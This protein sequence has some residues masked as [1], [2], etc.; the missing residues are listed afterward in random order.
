VIRPTR[1]VAEIFVEALPKTPQGRRGRLGRPAPN[2]H[3][4]HETQV[5]PFVDH[6]C[7]PTPPGPAPLNKYPRQPQSAR[8]S[9]GRIPPLAGRSR[10]GGPEVSLAGRP[11]P[12]LAQDGMDQI[13]TVATTPANSG[14]DS[15]HEPAGT[16]HHRHA[17]PNA[18]NHPIWTPNTRQ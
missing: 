5:V 15:F 6:C 18:E 1:M 12:K 11:T 7:V 16:Q 4:D 9:H 10:R 17:G 3:P 14:I 2:G 8:I 13:T